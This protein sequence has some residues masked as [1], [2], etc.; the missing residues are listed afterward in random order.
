M[1]NSSTNFIDLLLNGMSAAL[2]HCF[3]NITTHIKAI[4]DKMI[5]Y[6]ISSRKQSP[7]TTS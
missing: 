7:V 1:E 5:H 4:S 6:S 3:V 2:Q